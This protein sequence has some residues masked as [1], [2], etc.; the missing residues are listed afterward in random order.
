MAFASVGTLGVTVLPKTSG[1]TQALAVSADAEVGNVVVVGSAWDNAG[2]SQADTSQLSIADDS[3][4]TWIKIRERTYSA[5][6]ANDGVTVAV[7]VSKITTQIS[8]GANITVTSASARTA[9]VTGAWEFS[10][11]SGTLTF[12]GVGGTD[13]QTAS[14]AASDPASMSLASLVSQ[15]YLLVHAIGSEGGTTHTGDADYTERHD[16]ETTGGAVATNIALY[17]G[18]RIATLTGD[19]VDA[20]STTDR[21]HAQVLG[22]VYEAAGDIEK[23]LTP[24]TET[25]A[26]QAIAFVKTILKTITATAETD[27]AVAV[28]FT[29]GGDI[30]KT[31]APATEADA[32]QT[33]AFVKTILKTL[34]AAA[35]TDSA[36][37][38]T[39][40]KT[41]SKT[42]TAATETDAAQTVAFTQGGDIEKTLTPTVETDAA[43]TLTF[44]KTIFKDLTPAAELDVAVQLAITHDIAKMLTPAGETNLAVAL[45]ISGGVPVVAHFASGSPSGGVGAGTPRGGGPAGSP[46]ADVYAPPSP[47]QVRV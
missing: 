17:L 39:F 10:M 25:D 31:I 5:G 36:Q 43:Q 20:A 11:G 30:E 18:T 26:A 34:T 4:N 12:D 40:T 38:L 35:E 14:A 2:T 21:D 19:T 42:L 29:Q 7:W 23:T 27:A 22:A 45:S 24:A 16:T 28:S 1:T 32:A 15:E 6:A 13:Y 47:E 44:T 41:I 46:A 33:L 8:S 3:G 37:A 9:K